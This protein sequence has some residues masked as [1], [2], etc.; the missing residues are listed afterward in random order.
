MKTLKKA[1][2]SGNLHSHSKF[3]IPENVKVSDSLGIICVGL[4]WSSPLLI[5][6]QW[7]KSPKKIN[8]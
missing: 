1:E 6:I 3:L 5:A 4:Y 2:N 8:D 7:R